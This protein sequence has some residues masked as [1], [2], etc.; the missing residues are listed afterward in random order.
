MR[1]TEPDWSKLDTYNQIPDVCEKYTSG[2]LGVFWPPNSKWSPFKR[3]VLRMGRALINVQIFPAQ[4]TSWYFAVYSFR[5]IWRK[6]SSFP[7]STN[8][9]GAPIHCLIIDALGQ[10]LA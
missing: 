1:V 3:H 5:P 9:S 10:R 8:T 4:S 7:H 6:A 2:K